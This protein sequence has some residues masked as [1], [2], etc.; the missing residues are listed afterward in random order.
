MNGMPT[1]KDQCL[2]VFLH[3]VFVCACCW[4]PPTSRETSGGWTPPTEKVCEKEVREATNTEKGKE[5]EEEEPLTGK[6][7]GGNGPPT[8]KRGREKDKDKG[9][10]AGTRE[11]RAG[12]CLF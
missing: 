6:G 4:E 11:R 5:E 8:E 7:E 3:G 9:R 2:R 12:K 10:A 1:W